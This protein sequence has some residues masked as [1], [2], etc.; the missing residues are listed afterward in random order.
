[1]TQPVQEPTT[2]RS[3]SGLDWGQ[4]QLARRPPIVNAAGYPWIVIYDGSTTAPTNTW[5]PVP[6]TSLAYD[7]ALVTLGGGIFDVDT[8][9]TGDP[10]NTRY[11]II[12]AK[13]GVYYA[14]L[15]TEW[16]NVAADGANDFGYAVQD[17]FHP[18]APNSLLT[19]VE[20][21]RASA[22]WPKNDTTSD[23]E[24]QDNNFLF[25]SWTVFLNQTNWAWDPYGKQ[26]TGVDRDLSGIRLYIV[27]L[28]YGDGTNWT[29]DSI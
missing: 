23:F 3:V 18:A 7:P 16:D 4:S 14:E 6:F 2:Q 17:M 19:N 9:D 28:P 20:Y 24:M 22:D 8:T 11:R 5:M 10:G 1:M 29:F 26:T 25:S 27:A 15:W 21:S 12:T 13:K